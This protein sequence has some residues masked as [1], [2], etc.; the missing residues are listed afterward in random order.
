M[1]TKEDIDEENK[2]IRH[3]RILVDLT[4]NIILQTDLPLSE[5]YKLIE[6]TRRLAV[7]L[8]PGKEEVYDLI[9]KPR[10]MRLLSQRYLIPGG[11]N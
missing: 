10:F 1:P 7:I 9:Y 6:G 11:R 2:K 4:S 3:L 5:A 8:F